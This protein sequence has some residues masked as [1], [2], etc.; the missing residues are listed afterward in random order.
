MKSS[1]VFGFAMQVASTG[2]WHNDEGVLVGED[3]E[4]AAE[5]AED[6][7]G[8]IILKL[9]CTNN[10]SE[11]W[12]TLASDLYAI[13]LS[14]QTAYASSHSQSSSHASWLGN[15]SRCSKSGQIPRGG[16]PHQLIV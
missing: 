9:Y 6:A 13:R 10:V 16:P 14:A 11:S 5:R 3:V 7:V 2:Q 4:L 12:M 1:N 15:R 8:T